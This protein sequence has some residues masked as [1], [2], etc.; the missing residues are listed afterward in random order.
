MFPLS[1]VVVLQNNYAQLASINRDLAY[2]F[3]YGVV[4][5]YEI[6]PRTWERHQLSSQLKSKNR[7]K[8]TFCKGTVLYLNA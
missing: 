1:N 7:L 3:R 8:F 6:I 2:S 4:E 5:K